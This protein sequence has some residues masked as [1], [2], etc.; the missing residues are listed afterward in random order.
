MLKKI[1]SALVSLLIIFPVILSGCGDGTVEPEDNEPEG[2]EPEGNEPEDEATSGILTFEFFTKED[3]PTDHDFSQNCHAV[4]SPGP[5][6][7]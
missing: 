7:T 3:E 1:L 2:N 5:P 6:Y 4:Y